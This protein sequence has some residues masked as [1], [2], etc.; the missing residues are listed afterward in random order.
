[1]RPIAIFL[2]LVVCLCGITS[3]RCAAGPGDA[4][5]QSAR[6]TSGPVVDGLALSITLPSH[7][8]GTLGKSIIVEL[9]NQGT[10][11]K[12]FWDAFSS[13]SYKILVGNQHVVVNADPAHATDEGPA[14]ASGFPIPPG[15]SIFFHIP[16]SAFDLP[17]GTQTVWLES[18]R[19]QDAHAHKRLTL[20][21]NPLVV[22]VP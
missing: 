14:L 10:E 8:D 16:L 4:L 5:P 18:T 6:T 15:R 22:T 21:S 17:S 20:V 3:R 2:F 11:T 12:Y 9:R 1:M 13:L 7:A 19:L